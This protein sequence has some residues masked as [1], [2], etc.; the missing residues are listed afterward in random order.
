LK[1]SKLFFWALLAAISTTMISPTYPNETTPLPNGIDHVLY[2]SSSLQLGMDEIEA[3]LGVRPV[4]GGR[5]PQY[6]THNALLSLG[7]GVYLE[8]IARDP[9]LPAPERGPLFDIPQDEKSR[10]FTW[11]FRAANIEQS[12]AALRGVGIELGPVESGNRI[13]PDGSQISWQLTDPYAMPLDGAV[14][15]LIDWGTTAHPSISAPFGGELVELIIEHPQPDSVRDALSV[16]GA[17]VEV[18]GGAQFR[19]SAKIQTQDGLVTLQ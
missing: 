5:H 18:V 17:D 12:A 9:D 4:P 11:V 1:R 16:L 7:P 8:V 13:R 3:L 14:P 10:L 6:G 2:A 19:I 15:F